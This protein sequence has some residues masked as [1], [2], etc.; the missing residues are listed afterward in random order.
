M[1]AGD[2]ALDQ[3]AQPDA[4]ASAGGLHALHDLVYLTGGPAHVMTLGAFMAAVSLTAWRT[5]ALPRWVA[6]TGV[7]AGAI[8]ILSLA[9]LLW[10]PASLVLPLGRGLGFLWIVFDEDRQAWHDKIARTVVP[11]TVPPVLRPIQEEPAEPAL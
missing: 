4:I 11:Y 1:L 2:A 7:A 3:G 6:A 10:D 8:S 9:A 5:G